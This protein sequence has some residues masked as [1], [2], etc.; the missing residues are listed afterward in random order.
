M[1]GGTHQ[2]AFALFASVNVHLHGLNDLVVFGE[3]FALGHVGDSRAGMILGQRPNVA[4]VGRESTCG[5]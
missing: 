1:E 5:W 3:I 2:L 4:K